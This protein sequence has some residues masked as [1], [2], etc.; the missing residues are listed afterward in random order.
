MRNPIRAIPAV[1]AFALALATA[2]AAYTATTGFVRTTPDG[3][4]WV[5]MP[6][7]AGRVG[8]KQLDGPDSDDPFLAMTQNS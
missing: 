7:E 3:V 2:G 5:T 1:A 4:N 8:M 6:G